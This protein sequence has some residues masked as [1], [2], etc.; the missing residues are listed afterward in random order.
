MGD[1]KSIANKYLESAAKLQDSSIKYIIGLSLLV[2]FCWS[3]AEQVF[4]RTKFEA[5][6][7][8]KL[9]QKIKH[10]ADDPGKWSKIQ[11]NEYDSLKENLVFRIQ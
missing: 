5:I 9:D 6:R 8:N 3:F 11:H 10:F 4:Y 7:L 2:L 1:I